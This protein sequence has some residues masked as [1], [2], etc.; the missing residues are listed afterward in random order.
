MQKKETIKKYRTKVLLGTFVILLLFFSFV[1]CSC[2]SFFERK[3][4]TK[5][6]LVQNISQ[7]DGDWDTVARFLYEW[8]FPT[9]NEDKFVAI[10]RCVGMYY[11]G[12]LPAK[13]EVARTCANLFVEYFYDG[14]DLKNS[15]VVTDALLTCYMASFGDRYA[16]YKNA[17]AYE[18]FSSEMSGEEQFVGVGVRVRKTK[19]GA[20]Y[21]ASVING[22]PAERAGL[23][24]GD[25][26][27]SVDGAVADQCG[28]EET[29]KLI[30]GKEGEPVAICVSRDG[31]LLTVVP[32]R[33]SVDDATVIYSFDAESGY[34]LIEILSFKER[35]D[36]DF[37]IAVDTL[38]NLGA[39]GLV[40]DLRN[41]LGGIL[42]TV[43]NMI[44]YLVDDG[45]PVVSYKYNGQP[46]IVLDSGT[47]G[48]RL[49]LPM[50]VITN[51]YTASAAEIFVAALRDYEMMEGT[52]VEVTIVGKTSFGKG[53]M[54][55][56]FGFADGS[57][58]TLTVA[59]Y[60]PPSGENYHGVGVFPDTEVEN[61]LS[62]N[63]DAQL[64]CAFDAMDEYFKVTN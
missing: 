3:A 64:D 60:N 46:E 56:V 33:E 32:D 1:F 50:V 23:K 12:E 31:E 39:K 51:E 52:G 44:S 35:T 4:P 6:R 2:S 21:I 20:P 63:G 36:D 41:N 7:I 34:G 47:D 18:D 27:I 43:V 22:S 29:V 45:L 37:K 13:R 40:F 49:D 8:E 11:C 26:I 24:R 30:A 59:Y 55:K 54:Q 10:E 38:V 61:D 15:A 28:Y 5:E 17:A 57:V 16:N 14:I 48:H 25:V 58:I 19:E 42:D 9:F 53:V 62:V